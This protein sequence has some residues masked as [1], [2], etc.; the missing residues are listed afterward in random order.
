ML[1][2]GYQ[3]IRVRC[4]L[5][6]CLVLYHG[7]IVIGYMYL[8]GFGLLLRSKRN[9]SIEQSIYFIVTFSVYFLNCIVY[10][11]KMRCKGKIKYMNMSKII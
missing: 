5:Y 2:E 1:K 7:R 8:K 9:I 6:N 10:D 4:N 3:S 11:S